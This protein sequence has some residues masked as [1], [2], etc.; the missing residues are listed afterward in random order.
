MKKIYGVIVLVILGYVGVAQ[1]QSLD[2]VNEL[3][4]ED[5]M[6]LGVVTVESKYEQKV[7][8]APSDVTLITAEDIRLGGFRTL[9]EVMNAVPGIYMRDDRNYNFI[10]V[11]GLNRPGDYNARI[12]VTI[13]GHRMNENIYDSVGYKEDGPIALSLIDRIE[14]IRGPASS[15]Y[16][17][18]AFFGVINIVTKDSTKLKGFESHAS[19]GSFEAKRATVNYGKSFGGGNGLIFGVEGV[20]ITGPE[21]RMQGLGKVDKGMD[22]EETARGFVSFNHGNFDLQSSFNSRAKGIPT[23]Y[24][25]SMFNV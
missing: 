15:L 22:F 6:N 16:G 2:D 7:S 20:D 19:Y 3:T 10:G 1:S 18:N 25:D 8:E 14:V 12:L 9:Y 4:L 21:L 23:A 24:Y 11:R 5:I 13:N 17:N